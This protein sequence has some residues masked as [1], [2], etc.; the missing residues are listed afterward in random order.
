MNSAYFSNTYCMTAPF[1]MQKPSGA[2]IKSKKLMLFHRDRNNDL[3]N[4][5]VKEN[6]QIRIHASCGQD[7]PWRNA[8]FAL[9]FW[10]K[11]NLGNRATIL[12][13]P[14]QHSTPLEKLYHRR[15]GGSRL[16]N[17]INQVEEEY[18]NIHE[19]QPEDNVE[20]SEG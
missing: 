1:F 20:D 7:D 3:H 10:L 16:R 13:E 14:G 4:A 5:L 11:G 8:S 15:N 17:I 6:V 12:D 19:Y 2:A 9:F 18:C